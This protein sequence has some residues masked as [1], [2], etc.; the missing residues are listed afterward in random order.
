MNLRPFARLL[1]F[2][3]ESKGS[4]RNGDSAFGSSGAPQEPANLPCATR[5]SSLT[6]TLLPAHAL[7][8]TSRRRIHA[9][10]GSHRQVLGG[11]KRIAEIPRHRSP[12]EP[13]LPPSVINPPK[14]YESPICRATVSRKLRRSCTPKTGNSSRT[15]LETPLRVRPN[16]CAISLSDS[17]MQSLQATSVR[18]GGTLRAPIRRLNASPCRCHH[19]WCGTTYPSPRLL[20]SGVISPARRRCRGRDPMESGAPPGFPQGVPVPLTLRWRELARTSA[21]LS[22]F[23]PSWRRE[24][25]VAPWLPG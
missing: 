7:R 9:L 6:R 25:D 12:H 17:P 3:R 16:C 23:P 24:I 2:S 15:W 21:G 13:S 19:S 8:L 20:S 5:P 1:T 11:E 22:A 14:R 4:V 10:C 18:F